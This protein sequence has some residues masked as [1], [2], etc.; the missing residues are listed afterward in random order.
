MAT[1][2][3]E[4]VAIALAHLE[5]LVLA[6]NLEYLPRVPWQLQAAVEQRGPPPFSHPGMRTRIRGT[7][8]DCWAIRS[9]PG[10]AQIAGLQVV[11]GLFYAGAFPTATA[12]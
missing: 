5:F 7:W 10:L 1:G 12:C 2:Q 3:I 9:N 11:A 8:C 6:T 4:P